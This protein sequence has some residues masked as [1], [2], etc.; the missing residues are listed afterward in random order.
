M[1]CIISLLLIEDF[2]YSRK[3]RKQTNHER[4]KVLG[5]G[6]RGSEG[7]GGWVKGIVGLGERELVVRSLE[8]FV[9]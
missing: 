7:K 2:S 9:I 5:E 1:L 4:E 8:K 6:S 3:R